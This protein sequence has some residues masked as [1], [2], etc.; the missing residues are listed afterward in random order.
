[1]RILIITALALLLSL[2]GSLAATPK[3]TVPLTSVTIAVDGFHCMM[4]PDSL[5]PD[6]TKLPGVRQVHATL[7][8]AQVTATLDETKQPVSAFVTAIAKHPRAMEPAQSYS[9]WL[10]IFINGE[11]CSKDKHLCKLGFEDLVKYLKATKGVQS[12]AL[13][14]TGKVLHVAFRPGAL[15]TTTQLTAILT[16]HDTGFTVKY[17]APVK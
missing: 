4:C 5:Q 15:L 17:T 2:T 11:M 6:L 9:A 13:D 16:K 1:M 8:P 10:L 7:T 14:D 12:A 3:G